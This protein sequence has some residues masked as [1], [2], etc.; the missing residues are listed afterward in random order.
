[1][2]LSYSWSLAIVFLAVLLFLGFNR[3]SRDTFDNYHSVLWSDAAGYHA[4]LPFWFDDQFINL[5]REEE[6]ELIKKTGKG[7]RLNHG[8]F[9]SKYSI[10][11]AILQ[12]PSYLIVLSTGAEAFSRPY[13]LA[14]LVTGIILGW[15]GIL[16]LIASMRRFGLD[17]V[18]SAVFSI[19][20][21]LATNLFYYTVD[22]PGYSHVY[23][24]FAFGLLVYLSVTKDLSKL[25]VRLAI[26]LALSMVFLLRAFNLPFALLLMLA[27]LH[28]RGVIFWPLGLPMIRK[29]G[30][31]GLPI[32]LALVLHLFLNSLMTSDVVLDTYQGESF[33]NLTKP[34]LLEVLFSTRNGLILYS[35]V[36]IMLLLGVLLNRG[37][38]KW[39]PTAVFI[40]LIYL[41]AS[42]WNWELG[43]AFGYRGI[44]EYA[45]V[46]SLFATQSVDRIKT[47][48]GRV[49]LISI[50]VLLALWSLKLMYTYDECW[51]EGVWDY[52]LFFRNL[53]FGKT[54]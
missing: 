31:I 35:P 30:V 50:L 54:R 20:I 42:W 16:L 1:M 34:R 23:S 11:V 43:C 26:G 46:F 25:G 47:K 36:W 32:L 24:F 4:H 21:F 17:G 51:L 12:A 48:T 8:A 44:A 14:V 15:I 40:G 29:F 45:G 19:L 9:F 38:V 3:H 22:S 52:D 5:T 2:K 6:K 27:V 10:G 39:L 28:L 37:R 7:F 53:L 13:H 41:Y 33:T 49:L 18:R